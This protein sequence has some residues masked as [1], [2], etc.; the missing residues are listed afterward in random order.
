M[1]RNTDNKGYEE[2]FLTTLGPQDDKN[3]NLFLD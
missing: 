1:M 3:S 2:S